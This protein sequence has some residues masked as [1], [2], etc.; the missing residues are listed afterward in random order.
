M[1]MSNTTL[2]QSRDFLGAA[3]IQTPTCGALTPATIRHRYIVQGEMTRQFLVFESSPSC[4][5]ASKGKG[6]ALVELLDG[7][8]FFFRT[9]LAVLKDGP[10]MIALIDELRRLPLWI[11][12]WKNAAD[13]VGYMIGATLEFIDKDF[14]RI[15]SWNITE[16]KQH[17]VSWL[18]LNQ[19]MVTTQQINALVSKATDELTSELSSK[20]AEFMG[21]LDQYVFSLHGKHHCSWQS[22]HNY[23]ISSNEQLRRYRRQA[24]TTFPLVIQQIFA[25]P[26]DK[27]T[28]SIMQAID[29]GMPLV[30][31]MAN[32]FKCPK[33]CIRH[34]GG[35]RFEDI[36]IQWTGRLKELLMLLGSLDVN[37]LP[38]GEQEWK[39]FGETIELLSALTKMP[40]TSLSGRLL[41]GEL[42]KL[43]WRC[44][45]DS[46]AG[47]SERARA[48]ERLSENFR[49][50]IVAT[51]WVDGKSCV[52]GIALQRL[53]IESACTLGLTRLER[54]AR[55]WLAEE[56]RLDSKSIIQNP[57]GFPVIL[58]SPLEVGEMKVVQL[59]ESRV[60]VSE[61]VRMHN[62]VAG[63][64]SSCA[65][66]SAY[67]FSV[68]DKTDASCVT[69]EY[70]LELSK[71]GLP[72]LN[73]IQ[74]KGF[75]NSTPDNRYNEA[76]AALHRY[77]TSPFVRRRILGLV[78]YRKAWDK[79]GSGKAMKYVR[80]LEFIQFL[81]K[82]NGNRLD[83][84]LL[85]AEAIRLEAATTTHS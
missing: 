64:V 63:F 80:S 76:L 27:S 13:L 5:N 3:S 61:G 50:A 57:N 85:V 73:F 18:A 11:T 17:A 69:V 70:R 68:R 41:L 44:R 1:L 31:H 28:A 34:L 59:T 78:A 26:K 58:E 36:G 82:E 42:S 25:R 48:I 45:I 29:K 56:M 75:E 52:T 4:L 14:S 53:V 9:S 49:Q 79:G 47:F 77:A 21:T 16:W 46:N 30:E 22:S 39:V 72:I 2:S 7:R 54:L 24:D 66:G 23:F 83:F 55:K 60:L 84:D 74:Q 51:A 32:L 65:S 62:C 10:E 33:K 37:R 38:K 40:T 81:R 15:E 43:N 71:A 67:I 35:L 20:L 19:P 12:D 8:I 6:I